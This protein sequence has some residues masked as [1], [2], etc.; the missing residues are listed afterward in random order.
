MREYVRGVRVSA[1]DLN[2]NSPVNRANGIVDPRNLDIN[3][4]RTV[5]EA[6]NAGWGRLCLLG[7]VRWRLP[8]RV[9]AIDILTR[10]AD[11]CGRPDRARQRTS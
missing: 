2:N 8:T 4:L 5:W 11:L 7:D 6:I 10:G 9:Y 3:D 1:V